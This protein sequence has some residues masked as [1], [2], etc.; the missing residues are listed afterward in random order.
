MGRVN[1]LGAEKITDEVFFFLAFHS[2]S[3]FLVIGKEGALVCYKKG[4]AEV[5]QDYSFEWRREAAR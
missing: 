2:L 1:S 4:K 5:R 3:F